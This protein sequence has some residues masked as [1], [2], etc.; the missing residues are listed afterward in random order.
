M[1]TPAERR[2]LLERIS[3][4]ADDPFGLRSSLPWAPENQ[5]PAVQETINQ[6]RRIP[7]PETG[8]VA[9]VVQA[10]NEA[11]AEPAVTPGELQTEPVSGGG[12]T[13]PTLTPPP[14]SAAASRMAK[15]QGIRMPRAPRGP[16][17]GSAQQAIEKGIKQ[18]EELIQQGQEAQVEN[19]GRVRG[20]LQAQQAAAADQEMAIAEARQEVDRAIDDQ[21]T[22]RMYPNVP[23]SAGSPSQWVAEQKAIL[24]SDVTT[25]EL[26]D[27]AAQALE[28]A[29]TD[30]KGA[31]GSWWGILLSSIAMGMGAFGSALTGG[32]NQAMQIINGAL[33]RREREQERK[34]M[35]LQRVLQAKERKGQ[36]GLERTREDFARRAAERAQNLEL[37]KLGL[38]E[39]MAGIQ[40]GDKRAQ[41]QVLRGNIEMETEKARAAAAQA[42]YQTKMTGAI[43]LAKIDEATRKAQAGPR[44]KALPSAL[45]DKLGSARQLRAEVARAKEQ[46]GSIGIEAYAGASKVPF[47]GTA[48]KEW[49]AKKKGLAQSIARAVQGAR[50]SDVDVKMNL[51]RLPNPTSTRGFGASLLDELEDEGKRAI[52]SK[53]VTYMRGGYDVAN[54]YQQFIEVY[55]I[56]PEALLGEQG[57]GAGGATA[58]EEAPAKR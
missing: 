34:Q 2:G 55:G 41:L 22:V 9:P 10:Q 21:V 47:V 26:K 37:L 51:E 28:D 29:K 15:I 31:L 5:S 52:A 56:T 42:R 53:L 18:Q 30:T 19:F 1:A 48:S 4:F 32:P 33:N 45:A 35:R 8:I 16:D 43:A 3:Q 27:Q 38:D 13:E 12:V 14:M 39:Q 17:F 57:V 25:P 49:E 50:P 11:M 7:S 6:Y 46:F 20:E 44:G 58:I 54:E 24:A 23:E 40:S 36:L